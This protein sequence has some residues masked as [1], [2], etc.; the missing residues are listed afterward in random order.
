MLLAAILLPKIWLVMVEFAV[1]GVSRLF[2]LAIT[3]ILRPV[4]RELQ[5]ACGFIELA[6][7]WFIMMAFYPLLFIT[8]TS[9]RR[10]LRPCNQ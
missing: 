8:T 9:W 3:S 2:W 6:L 10:Q 5:I 1:R 4:E 7:R